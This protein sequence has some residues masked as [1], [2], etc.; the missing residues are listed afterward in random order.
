MNTNALLPYLQVA[1][2]TEKARV[3]SLKEAFETATD[4]T[5][6]TLLIDYRD[7][8]LRQ[9]ETLEDLIHAR[10]GGVS[11]VRVFVHQLLGKIGETVSAPLAGIDPNLLTAVRV[12]GDAQYEVALYDAIASVAAADGESDVEKAARQLREQETIAL[13][14]L[15]PFLTVPAEEEQTDAAR[16]FGFTE[17]TALFA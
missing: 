13:E 1:W 5:L 7:D 4:D 11:T 17:A 6:R 2:R 9:V 3:D 12:C 14:S 8:T 10:G 16:S 15:T